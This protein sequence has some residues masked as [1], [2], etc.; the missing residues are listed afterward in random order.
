LESL[1]YEL[2]QRL[3]PTYLR[4]DELA[5]LG[6]GLIACRL[7]LADPEAHMAPA[8]ALEA[9][10]ALE[11]LGWTSVKV[12]EELDGRPAFGGLR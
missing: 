2:R 11:D 3:E 10:E 4:V 8:A 9:L 12:L 1:V 5:P 6:H 7:L